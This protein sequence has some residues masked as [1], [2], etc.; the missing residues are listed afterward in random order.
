M[1]PDFSWMQRLADHAE[2]NDEILPGQTVLELI[3]EGRVLIEGHGG[4][5]VYSDVEI[6]VKV[7]YGVLKIVGRNLKLSQ[8][9]LYKLI[10][11]G[12]ISEIYLIRRNQV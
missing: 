7:K 3:G 11:S 6:C 5:Y 8:M 4:V 2:L 9:T 1:A 12:F 10:I